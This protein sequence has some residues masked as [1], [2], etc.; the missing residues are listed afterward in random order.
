MPLR[1]GD[2]DGQLEG[3]L[4]ALRGASFHALDTVVV[5]VIRGEI[6]GISKTFSPT[7]PEL[8]QAIRDEMAYVS[9]QIEL[10]IARME[11]E[12]QRPISVKPMLLVDRIAQ[13]KQRMIDEGRA[14]LFTV[15]SHPGFLARKGELPTG[16]IYCA[17][18]GAA[19]GPQGSASRPSPAQEVPD[20][21]TADLDW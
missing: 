17:I 21:V 4:I 15:T 2:V 1:K 14:Q 5:K 12:D 10:A 6:D 3:Y 20:P 16:G 7:P 11:I 13:A 8:S 18:L 19:Y 9:K